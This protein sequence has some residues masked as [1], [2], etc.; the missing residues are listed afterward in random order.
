MMG[1]TILTQ[2]LSKKCAENKAS[3]ITKNNQQIPL[4][5]MKKRDYLSI[6]G[7]VEIA[8]PYYW[9]PGSPGLFPM[10]A[11]LNLPKHHHSYLLDKWIQ[12]RVTEE[13]FEEA[14]K[15]ICD[16]LNQKI[17]KRLTQQITAQAVIPA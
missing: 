11:E 5:S 13:P 16:L 7:D 9:K 4:H 12:F 15:S 8:R 2:F 14:I 3:I 6:F 10:D 17:S 1:K